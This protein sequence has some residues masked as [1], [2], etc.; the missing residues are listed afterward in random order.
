MDCPM[1]FTSQFLV[2]RSEKAEG[3]CR[4]RQ[5]LKHQVHAEVVLVWLIIVRYVSYLGELLF[6]RCFFA[7]GEWKFGIS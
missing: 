4:V 1:V 2:Y 5:F 3:K 6:Q 7:N